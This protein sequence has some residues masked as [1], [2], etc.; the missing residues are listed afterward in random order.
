M[1]KLVSQNE[2]AR[3]VGKSRQYISR[4]VKEGRITLVDGKIDPERA[5]MEFQ[6]TTSSIWSSPNAGGRPRKDGAPPKQSPKRQSI[7]L[8]GQGEHE[9]PSNTG[10]KLIQAKAMKETINAKK[11]KIELDQMEG[12]VL[13]FGEVE[14]VFAEAMV[15]LSTAL[16]GL[17]GRIADD[18]AGMTDRAEIRDLIFREC[19]QLRAEIS[20]KLS[21]I[22]DA[23]S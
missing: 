7:A 15:I 18:V 13:D 9:V 3:R 16:D 11:A 6:A 22:S 19:R 8:A 4:M 21:K 12:K 5:D 1:S 20:E 2:Y 14:Q 17:G 10:A 23:K